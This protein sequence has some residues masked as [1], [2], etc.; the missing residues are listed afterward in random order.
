[1]RRLAITTAISLAA[2]GTFLLANPGAASALPVCTTKV[3][4]TGSLDHGQATCRS[5]E[6]FRVVVTC[7]P[8]ATSKYGSVYRGPWKSKGQRST[9]Y[10]PTHMP[11][12]ARVSYERAG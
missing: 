3:H 12:A 1:M 9:K 6:D 10:C 2:A 7:K 11:Y 8:S 5:G 4:R